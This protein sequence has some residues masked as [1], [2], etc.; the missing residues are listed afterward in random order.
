MDDQGSSLWPARHQ[1]GTFS[2]VDD[3]GEAARDELVSALG[4]APEKTDL[5]SL[6]KENPAS[7]EAA[8]KMRA[9]IKARVHN[10]E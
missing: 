4:K 3:E 1:C 9:L 2:I 10:F 6:V 5:P 7:D 8:Q